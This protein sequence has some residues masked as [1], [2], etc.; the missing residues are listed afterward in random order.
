MRAKLINLYR[1]KD[2]LQKQC[3]NFSV[4][5][6]KYVYGVHVNIYDVGLSIYYF[7][8]MINL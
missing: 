5:L 1:T 8:E 2:A 6:S 4:A 3:S 7:R